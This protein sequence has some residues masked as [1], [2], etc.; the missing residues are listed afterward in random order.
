MSDVVHV[1]WIAA[2]T[3]SQTLSDARFTPRLLGSFATD[4]E[5]HVAVPV[6]VKT[7]NNA[8]M[9]NGVSLEELWCSCEAK[10]GFVTNGCVSERHP[11]QYDELGNPPAPH[12][13]PII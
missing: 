2:P 1:H 4:A 3:T 13:S 6:E 8:Y 7:D 12:I 5:G 9:A 11:V 10:G